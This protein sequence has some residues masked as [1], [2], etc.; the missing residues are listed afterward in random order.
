[1]TFK[2]DVIRMM[3]KKR[4]AYQKVDDMQ[5]YTAVIDMIR[6]VKRMGCNTCEWCKDG[7]CFYFMPSEEANP[8][9]LCSAYSGKE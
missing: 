2:D 1:M 6:E 3:E 8:Y 7:I 5:G 4:D 9:N